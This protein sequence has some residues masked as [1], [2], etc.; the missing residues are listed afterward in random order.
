MERRN[1]TV[2][3]AQEFQKASEQLRENGFDDW[4]EEGIKRNA[5]LMD[6]YFQQ[7]RTIPVT[8][9]NIYK[10]VEA[11]KQDFAWLSLPEAKYYKTASENPAAATFKSW[12][13]NQKTLISTGDQGFQNA[14][15]ILEEI[16]N[17]RD[18]NLK[19]IQDAIMRIETPST[20]FSTRKRPPLH[21]VPTSRPADPR[22]HQSDGEGFLGK[23]NEPRWKRVQR[24]REER[25]A[26]ERAKQPGAAALTASAVA[27]AKHKAASIKGGTH[28][29]TEEIGRVFVTAG[30]EIDWPATLQARLTLQKSFNRAQ[31]VRRFVR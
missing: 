27:E 29:E 26:A 24:E 28:A 21:Y 18:I 31:E 1:Y 22:Q 10:A 16:G 7:N 12:F 23:T 4:S 8:V 6:E 20:K 13:A 3:D 25:E 14:V 19:T 17:G 11:R 9:A 2:Q 15:N 30:T 5:D